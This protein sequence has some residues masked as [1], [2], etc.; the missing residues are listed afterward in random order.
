MDIERREVEILPNS[1]LVIERNVEYTLILDLCW[2]S[3]AG[4][5]WSIPIEVHVTDGVI[6]DN[7]PR[8]IR[9]A[10]DELVKVIGD[11]LTDG[12]FKDHL[13]Q[14]TNQ[15]RI[16]AGLIRSFWGRLKGRTTLD[17][18]LNRILSTL[19]ANERLRW[20]EEVAKNRDLKGFLR[21]LP[22]M[23]T[24]ERYQDPREYLR[25]SGIS[26][27]M[28]A[29]VMRYWPKAV[30]ANLDKVKALEDAKWYP[31]KW[32]EWAVFDRLSIP[33][34]R[35]E[36]YKSL[37]QAVRTSGRDER[38]LTRVG[39][40]H[41]V[42][43]V[44]DASHR[45]KFYDLDEVGD[46]VET[47]LVPA[48]YCQ[49][50]L[51]RMSLRTAVDLAR[52]WHYEISV[53]ASQKLAKERERNSRDYLY[54]PGRFPKL[55]ENL[56]KRGVSVPVTSRELLEVGEDQHH[57]VG[58]FSYVVKDGSRIIAVFYP[59]DL[60]STKDTVTVSIYPESGQVDQEYL[61]WD[62]SVSR[63]TS[64]EIAAII[65]ACLPK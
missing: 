9:S 16:S 26:R 3:K 47:V 48:V 59:G 18:G 56:L 64:R 24:L 11:H 38:R 32:W 2:R 15:T 35:R 65:A 7:I 61:A 31:S 30:Q 8:L 58:T 55:A 41:L 10:R 44:L 57:C 22:K 27:K 45:Y 54:S 33:S 52:R 20:R 17:I 40:E 39:I 14:R 12:W 13:Y 43:Y 62:K 51:D 50:A 25:T 23:K 34:A 36:T 63:A 21:W 29:R 1:I 60:V 53:I 4:K 5:P 49:E 42:H 6:M 37:L 28:T 19:S 46:F